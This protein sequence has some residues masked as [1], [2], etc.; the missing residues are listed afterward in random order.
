LALFQAIVEVL[1]GCPG[2]QP[3]VVEHLR[4]R[5]AFIMP[6]IRIQV[7]KTVMKSKPINLESFRK[8]IMR[9]LKS[10]RLSWVSEWPTKKNIT[11]QYLDLYSN[12]PHLRI[13]I[14]A[15]TFGAAA[16]HFNGFDE[17]LLFLI[18]ILVVCAFKQE[19]MT[20]FR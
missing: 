17:K 15:S 18:R 10:K 16:A 6:Q 3:F 12:S 11:S 4:T 13:L 20:F 7:F 5:V 9:K 1:E 2:T 14:Q 19:E 8:E